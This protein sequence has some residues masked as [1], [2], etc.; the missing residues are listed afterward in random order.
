MDE[1][2]FAWSDGDDQ[3]SDVGRLV[4]SEL[5]PVEQA[6]LCERVVGCARGVV[7]AVVPKSRHRHLDG[8]LA[9]GEKV[10]PSP[11]PNLFVSLEI[12]GEPLSTGTLAAEGRSVSRPISSSCTPPLVMVLR[13]GAKTF[14]E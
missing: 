12:I 5:G 14:H 10:K 6:K 7:A 13:G 4:L 9:E 1:T 3:N 2:K 11:S 8:G